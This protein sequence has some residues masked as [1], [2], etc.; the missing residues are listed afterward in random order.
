MALTDEQ[1]AALG[2]AMPPPDPATVMA[3]P[4]APPAAILPSSAQP[5]YPSSILGDKVAPGAPITHQ[6]LTAL[7]H[8]QGKELF[9]DLM[10]KITSA[11][12]T[13]DYFR[14]RQEQLDYK[15]QH[16]WGDPVSAHPGVLGKIL[17]GLSVAGNIAGDI[18]APGVMADIPGTQMHNAIESAGNER[19]ILA[20][21]AEANQATEAGAKKTQAEAE[22]E[23]ADTGK[24]LA[25]QGG[26]PT[27]PEPLFDKD[28]NV[29]GF[30]TG[31]DLLSL[32][33]PNLTA[34]MKAIAAA[35]KPK[36]EK[37]NDFEQFYKDYITDNHL[38]DSA[39]NRLLARQEYAKA[40]QAPP[41]EQQQLIVTPDGTVMEIKPGMK[42]PQGS[43]TVTGDLAGAKPNAEEL[44]RSEMAENVNENLDKLEEI[45][46][47]R[48]DLFGPVAGRMTEA[49][50]WAGSND[51]DVGTLKTIHDNL[52]MAAQ[53]AHSMRSAQHVE[54]SANSVLN[55]FKNGPDAILAS[56]K[57]LR[58]SVKT[59]TKDVQQG[60][61][62]TRKEGAFAVPAG[63]PAAPK[64]DG[65][66]LKA[67]GK[68]IA[69]SKGGQ[70]V[71][72]E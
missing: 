25:D 46:K 60:N 70:W 66:T 3:P 39:H 13:T 45:V 9:H 37:L 1:L 65:H 5:K 52:G 16:P 21:E 63:A 18:V 41:H 29:V 61:P 31:T 47:R 14:Q 53:S 69:V 51:P 49:K 34:D 4:A 35:A 44:K 67:N 6:D 68:A 54:T 10:P 57:A 20:T 33:S 71:A 32:N 56:A 64:E 17:H 7:P 23:K 58:D 36:Q 40:G 15:A 11:P 30:N 42:V 22:K 38:P 55:G 28:G 48:P 62:S 19:G 2:L 27:K 8:D 26:K 59:F 24:E 50:M 43:K 72:P 12:G